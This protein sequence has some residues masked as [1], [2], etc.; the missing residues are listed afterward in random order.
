MKYIG[1]DLKVV[2]D[3]G[4][5]AVAGEAEADNAVSLLRLNEW[6]D[7]VVE[8]Q[9]GKAW[10]GVNGN[11]QLIE[12]ENVSLQGRDELTFK[13]F[14]NAPNRIMFDSVRLWKAD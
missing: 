7:L 9:H 10:V 11:G 12:H 4:I 6:L 14:A 1:E 13:T 5:I 8:F 3:P 2:R